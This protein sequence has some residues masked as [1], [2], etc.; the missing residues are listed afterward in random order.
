MSRRLADVEVGAELPEATSRVT[1]ADLVRYAGASGDFN[2]IHWNERVA[3]EVG[4][5]DVIAHGMLTAGIAVRAVTRWAGDPGA[6]VDYQVRFSRPVVVPDDG[7][8]AE[9]TVRGRVAAVGE[10]GRVRVD[11][12]VTSNGDKVLSLARAVVALS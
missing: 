3:R 9:L 4:L 8:G 2:V 6:V 12:T 7:S 10:D 11:L 5:P 1:R